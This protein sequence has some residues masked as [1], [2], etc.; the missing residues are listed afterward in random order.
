LTGII[1]HGGVKTNIIPDYTELEYSFRAPSK[2][3]LDQL[4]EKMRACFESAAYENV[5]I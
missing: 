2:K 4:R 1:K 5:E 3:E